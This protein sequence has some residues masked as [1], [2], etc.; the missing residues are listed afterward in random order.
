MSLGT[1]IGPDTYVTLA[2]TLYDDEGDE[3][4]G[5]GEDDPLTY[6]HG[7]AQIVPGL[8]RAL[9]GLT[10]GAEKSVVVLP[11]DGYGDYDPTGVIEIDKSDFP[12]PDGLQVGDEF[13][14][15]SDDG[16]EVPMTVLEIKEDSCVVD[17]NH[18]LAGETLR[19]EVRVLAVRPATDAELRDA[20]QAFTAG[21]PEPE[22]IT[23][24]RKP[25]TGDQPS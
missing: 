18:P 4:D 24:G 3:L 22:L 2:Y 14:A 11:R 15:E 20:D 5:A 17:T 13:V 12:R 1:Q 25:P 10:Q 16:D 21:Q 9:E 7:Y 23:L 19:F 6:V 8:E